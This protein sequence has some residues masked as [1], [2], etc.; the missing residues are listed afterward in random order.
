MVRSPRAAA[1]AGCLL[2]VLCV[3]VIFAAP[4]SFDISSLDNLAQRRGASRE[5]LELAIDRTAC[6]SFVGSRG[7]AVDSLGRV[8]PATLL[9]ASGCCPPASSDSS[10]SCKMCSRAGCCAVQV[11]CVSCCV[12]PANAEVRKSGLA[13][14]IAAKEI[15]PGLFAAQ[16]KSVHDSSVAEW[17][18]V[19]SNVAE[20][21]PALA[22]CV[23]RCRHNSRATF[24]QNRYAGSQ[25]HCFGV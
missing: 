14:G 11:D 24:H 10:S 20:G 15:F 23:Q 8:C 1:V 12:H 19:N 2:V 6:S 25:H 9:Q 21:G 22:Y 3:V 13:K 7:I 4:R 17:D 16:H 18:A 5:V